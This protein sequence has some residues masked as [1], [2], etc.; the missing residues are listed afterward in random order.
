MA[1]L[2]DLD[3]V[4]CDYIDIRKNGAIV[5]HLRDDPPTEQVLDILRLAPDNFFADI[6]Q[7]DTQTMLAAKNRYVVETLDVCLALFRHTYPDVTR[8]EIQAVLDL[9]QQQQVLAAFF[10]QAGARLQMQQSATA[11]PRQPTDSTPRPISKTV[12]RKR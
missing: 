11:S 12:K 6:D 9:T 8:E 4:T 3:A 10:N 7:N 1:V 5:W 2:L